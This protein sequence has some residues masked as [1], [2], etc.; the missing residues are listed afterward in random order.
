MTDEVSLDDWHL[1]RRFAEHDSQE[2]FAALTARYLNLVYSVCRRELADAETAEDVTQA[3][4]LI[5]ARKAPALG[6]NVVL[7]GWLFQTARFAAK[8]ARIQAQRRAA[9]EQKAAGAM[10]QQSEEREDAAWSEI[11]PLLNRSLAALRDGERDCVLLRFFQGLSFA[12]AG[13]ALG[14]SEEAVRKRVGRALEKMRRF[15]G[16]EGVLIPSV[17]LAA[18]LSAHA[19]KA[20]PATV[21]ATVAHLIT[22]IAPGPISLLAK[23]TLHAMRIAKLKATIGL[24]AVVLVGGAVYTF[25]RAEVAQAA[26]EHRETVMLLNAPVPF[27][28]TVQPTPGA[29]DADRNVVLT[30]RVFYEDGSPAGGVQVVAQSQTKAIIQQFDALRARLG[31]PQNKPLQVTKQEQEWSWNNAVSK[32][33]GSYELPV[34]ADIPYN[35]MVFDTTGK[36]VAASVEGV[37]GQKNTTVEVSDLLLTSGALVVGTVTDS[38]GRPVSGVSVNSYGPHRPV[39]SAAC[40]GDKT[41]LAGHYR[42]RVAPGLSRVYV[43]SGHGTYPTMLRWCQEG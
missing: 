13:T 43:A 31:V 34:G 29:K 12:E 27:P 5:L 35:V 33:D 25:V 8:N 18:L 28:D 14:L 23:G 17:A 20:A 26:Q 3:V 15:F 37:Q 2:A 22:G 16:K 39:S 4:F 32:P 19:A 7:S 9:Y 10:Q 11:E 6:R 38:T 30:G 41:D 21:A 1:L 36:W 40:I 24:V 42:L